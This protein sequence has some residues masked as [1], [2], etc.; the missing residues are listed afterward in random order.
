MIKVL[1]IYDESNYPASLVC[2]LK[3]EAIQV[4]SVQDGGEGAS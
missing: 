4:E 3:R 2:D 1:I